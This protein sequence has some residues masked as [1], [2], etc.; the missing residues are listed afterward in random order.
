MKSSPDRIIR[1]I[2]VFKFFKTAL[3]VA[4]GVGAFRLVHKDVAMVIKHLVDAFRIDPANHFV[5]V[6]LEKGAKLNPAQIRK[7]G[8]VSFIYASLF[9]TEGIGLW[10]M[11]P[12]AE[13]FTV[14]ITGSLVPLEIY[15]TYRHPSPVKI[16][17]LVLNAATVGYLIYRI[18]SRKSA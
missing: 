8:A 2:A 10:L 12:W 18:R 9:F 11:K 5:E 13:W 6:A 7:F 17:V 3:F 16:V 4:V 1:M 14:V 15:E